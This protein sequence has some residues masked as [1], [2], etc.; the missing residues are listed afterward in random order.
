MMSKHELETD[1]VR[2]VDI[3][4]HMLLVNIN[5]PAPQFAPAFLVKATPRRWC[6]Q[7]K[8]Y[9]ARSLSPALIVEVVI[10]EDDSTKK[11]TGTKT[12]WAW[13]DISNADRLNVNVKANVERLSGVLSYYTWIARRK[14]AASD[15]TVT[16]QL[17]TS[18][19]SP[20]ENGAVMRTYKYLSS[21]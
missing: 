4:E 10:M 2:L 19:H 8:V 15:G 9:F 6:N 21:R 7:Y 5:D 12:A 13:L 17:S 20:D 3:G 14:R 16:K 11:I 1:G 18:T